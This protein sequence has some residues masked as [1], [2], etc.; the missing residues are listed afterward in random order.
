M[1][2]TIQV[3]HS[4]LSFPCGPEESVLEAAQRA[5]FEIPY[6]CRRGV[7]ITCQGKVLAGSI[8]ESGSIHSAA[9]RGP[10]DSLFCSARPRSNI[11]ISPRRISR[12]LG[13]GQPREVT[14]RV[15][16]K[17]QVAPTVIR[18]HLRFPIGVRVA[19]RAGQYMDLLLPDGARRSYSMANSPGES[20]GV[21]MHIRL[22]P[23]GA[24]SDRLLGALQAGDSLRL[25]MPYGDVQL[26]G[27]DSRPLLLLATGTGFAPIASII[28]EAIR[29][30]WTRPIML[31]RG[32]RQAEDLYLPEL[33]ARWARRLRNFRYEP[34]LSRPDAAWA[35]RSGRVQ[36]AAAA[37]RPDMSG[38]QVYASGSPAMVAASRET[39][40]KLH[41]LP[42]GDFFADA[43]LPS[44]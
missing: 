25:S 5:G 10:F 12:P 15:F 41:G 23:G 24:F 4:D 35:G 31:Y 39:F 26:D 30:R 9:D 44:A 36:A 2:W 19:F 43:F 14:A 18:L 38:V 29:R 7:C 11:T 8:E 1:Q 27:E 17:Q 20:D 21:Q 28:E 6:S 40:T 13:L 34:I 22:H 33:P 32:A 16:R 37:D 42:E 3:A